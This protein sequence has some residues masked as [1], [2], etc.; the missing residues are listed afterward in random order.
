[1][2]CFRQIVRLFEEP[3]RRNTCRDLEIGPPMNFRKEELPLSIADDALTR[4]S[5]G[6]LEKHVKVQPVV[7]PTSPA[8]KTDKTWAKMRRLNMRSIQPLSDRER[9]ILTP[10]IHGKFNHLSSQQKKNN[11][12]GSVRLQQRGGSIFQ[13]WFC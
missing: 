12:N 11:S 3:L 2:D 7:Y 9:V 10:D 13:S 6:S 5:H 8:D 1:M 4:R